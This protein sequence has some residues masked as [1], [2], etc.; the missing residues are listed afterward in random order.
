M[1]ETHSC[2]DHAL[3]AV[4]SGPS[5]IMQVS[6]WWVGRSRTATSIAE[7]RFSVHLPEGTNLPSGVGSAIAIS[8]DGQ[9]LVYVADGATGRQLYR[10][11]MDDLEPT[12]IRGTEGALRPFMSP[13]GQWL[14]FDTDDFV[15][16]RV[17]VTGGDPF[18]LCEQCMDGFWGDD[19]HILFSW[20]G[21][22]WRIP[23]VGGSRELLAGPMPER[24]VP[25]LRTPV[26]LPGGTAVL[27]ENGPYAF[28][29]V[30][31]LS[32]ETREIILVSTD[33]T[34][35]LYAPSGHVVFARGTTLFAVPCIAP[36]FLDS[37]LTV[38]AARLPRPARR[39]RVAPAR[40]CDSRTSPA[41]TGRCTFA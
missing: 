30:G 28:G 22:L 1:S 34:G 12:P 3:S 8:S 5:R 13:D 9:T 29:G 18:T 21:S 36:G 7:Q 35:A 11:P 24:G 10:R 14:A 41:S 27:F 31:V 2:A 38:F 33:G 4:E 17:P 26:L 16:K 25:N 15:L 20:D 39:G 23:E 40:G 6:G 19:G 32:L 37:G